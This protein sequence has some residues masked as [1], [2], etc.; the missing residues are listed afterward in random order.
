MTGTELI[1]AVAALYLRE[2]FALGDGSGTA[3]FI[4]DSFTSD[5]T[6][7]VARA[8]LEDPTLS[9][10]VAVKLPA[11]F[12]AGQGLPDEVLT[13]ERATYYRN[14]DCPKPALLLAN[15][16][17]DEVQS[18]KELVPIGVPQLR[19]HPELWVRIAAD[20][21]DL[22]EDQRTWWERALAGL[23]DLQLLSLGHLADYVLATRAA[24]EEDGY[25][26]VRALGVALPAL[27]MPCDSTYFNALNDKVRTHA[28][29]WK[30]L[31]AA[32]A[33]KRACYLR[34]QTTSQSLLTTEDLKKVY[35]RVREDIPEICR[36]IVEAFIQAPSGWNAAAAAA[37]RCEWEDIKPLFDGL[38]REK[39]NLGQE[40]ISF[41]DDLEPDLLN[42]SERDYL[43]RLVARKTTDANEDDEQFYDAH[44]NELKEDAKLKSH[45]DRFVF[46]APL[47]TDDFLAGL[48]LCMER[49]FSQQPMA[50]RRRQLTIRCDSATSKKGLKDLNVEAGRYFAA[51]Y[52][53]LP[54][55][56]KPD[57]EWKV[58]KLFA[59]ADV[60]KE[61]HTAGVQLNRSSA[62]AA[63]QLKFVLS[64]DVE[65]LTGDSVQYF[66]QL[67]WTYH[68][69][70]VV[71][72]FVDDWSRLQ[73]HPLVRCRVSRK[74]SGSKG[75][76]QTVD[77]ANVKTLVPVY[78]QD[79]GSFV[80]AYKRDND[81]ALMWMHN[82][83]QAEREG[84][85]T[86]AVALRLREAFAEFQSCYGRAIRGFVDDGLAHVDLIA[87][88]HAYSTLLHVAC[89]DARGDRN[90]DLL[91]RPLLGIGTAMVDGGRET[92]I[93]TPW[94]PL[95][96]AAIARKAHIVVGLI[97]S[98]LTTEQVQ[99]GDTRLFFKD[100]QQ[101]LQHPFYPE[102]VLGWQGD[103]PRL[104]TW[105]DVVGDYTLHELPVAS[106]D[107]PDDTNENPTPAANQ[108][109]DLVKR[110][111]ALFPHERANLS[112]VLY[113]CASARLPQAV[114]D[115]IGG[116]Y[117]DED[118]VRCQVI[119][120]HRDEKQLGALYEKIIEA[121]DNDPDS[122]NASEATQDFM[123]R[124]RIAIMAH[125]APPPNKKDGCF[126][127]ISFSQDVIARHAHVEWYPV[128]ALPVPLETLMPPRWSRRRPAAKDDMK[129]V[130]F[131]CCPVQSEEG[132]SFLTAL[133]SFIKGDWDGN[134]SPRL[135]PARQL[136]FQ[137]GDMASIFEETHNLA[138]WVV[139][140]DELLD[141]RQLANQKVRVIRY[142]QSATQGRNVV[143]SSTASLDLLHQMVL[144]RIRALDLGVGDADEQR[145]A[146]RFV[147][148]ASDISG[149]IVLR[150]ARRGRNASELMGIVLSR[151]LIR[152]ELGTD[153]YFGW[154]FLDDY[155]AWLGQR[156]EQIADILML[157]P[158]QLPDGRLRLAMVIA[159]AKYIDASNLAAK[160]K[161]SQK[162]LR[163]TMKRINEAL[164]GAPERLDRDLWLARLSD[165][166][167][168]GV[169]FPASAQIDLTAWRR[170]IREGACDIYVRGYSHVFVTGIDGDANL[171]DFAVVADLDGAY[172]EVFGGADLRRLVLH[173]WR[174][175]S[176][177]AVREDVADGDGSAW[178]QRVYR[179][180]MDRLETLVLQP[181]PSAQ[182]D[183]GPSPAEAT[184]DGGDIASPPPLVEAAPS[185]VTEG[186]AVPPP[187]R[188]AYP[189]I[190]S[191]LDTGQAGDGQSATDRVWLKD[192]EGRMR[193]A[194]QQYQMRS[195]VLSSTLTPNA[196]LLKFAGGDDLTV[197]QVL[198]RRSQF[199]TTYGLDIISV[200][201]E[202]G[203]VAL[204]IA[205]LK[206]E[207]IQL[208]DIWRYWCPDSTQGNQELL[209]AVREDDG[210]PLFLAPAT[211][212][213]PHTLIAGSTGSGKSVLVQDI[214]L[215]I[216]ATN[217]P[218]QAQIILID[219]K[220]GVDYFSFDGLPHLGTGII[221]EREDALVRL[222]GLVDEMDARYRTFKAA[223][224]SN[225]AAYNRKVDAPDRLPVLWLIHDEFAEWMLIEEYKQE[226]TAIVSRLGVKA[227]AAGIY[228]VFAAQ[229]P[230]NNVMPLQLRANLG[231]R[232]ILRVDSEGTSEIALG[233]RG[234]ERLLGKGHLLAKLEGTPLT[235]AQVPLVAEEFIEQVVTIT[236]EAT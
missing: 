84:L 190:V 121:A 202:P 191:L 113:N 203:V 68:P 161:E 223:R 128:G 174:D 218:G 210:H 37:A 141:R 166:I 214:I 86:S 62:R 41:Y 2:Q 213:A 184:P 220:Q 101:E 16:G 80:A 219:P 140:Y 107:G 177:L 199:L 197:E 12:L 115:K 13:E 108:V 154:Y 35:D 96:M 124:L 109:L 194:L 182:P 211:Q 207:V 30:A 145:L 42:N 53:G 147:E 91:L 168:D 206:R 83:A 139:N 217:T 159:E 112:V 85:V 169:Q 59:F 57:V 43:H 186:N 157:S 127:D 11:H 90:R 20:G 148:D 1:G 142:K 67:V 25:P 71:S 132:W 178:T 137:D 31:Y 232:L 167:L 230:D 82:I 130:V 231:N 188:W 14:A 173:Y 233:E 227:R 198:K 216:A 19:D 8:V 226:V 21:I 26:L 134:M 5:Q 119:L 138:N 15:T 215:A 48:A 87:Q 45:W 144:H 181:V 180:P 235:Y 95:R 52:R 66:T 183:A 27:R 152:Q 158:E 171:S 54:A 114:V 125:Q 47:E 196:A 229:R 32:A 193:G 98:L 205:R 170:A 72:E 102:I 28:S 100:L 55:L 189:A 49:L 143:I 122:F 151:F 75:T 69:T 111:L 209:I 73:D 18:L 38:K 172:Q 94:H 236:M 129:S 4:I 61:W 106:D 187:A 176:P 56:L 65:S 162:Q 222:H 126:A 64:L 24:I 33:N 99:F 123:A 116:I 110:Y 36:D 175:E 133:T 77:L 9:A 10:R 200:Q 136:N 225:L 79:S 97:R 44:R 60:V 7:A 156:E 221:D 93:T 76:P 164:F 58:G 17:D 23:Q 224:A 6:A 51:R 208:Q 160:R 70:H 74:T 135:L 34:K 105:T 165:L 50:T 131:L 39:Y 40:T 104:L 146:H 179:R 22:P 63:L 149:D 228:L 117:E 201:P 3:R 81:I 185:V 192:I 163:D 118:D 155:A 103:E 150:A 234:A 204:S 89:R 153:R 46:G 88:L 78:S 212:H 120:R 92:A 29:R 195:K